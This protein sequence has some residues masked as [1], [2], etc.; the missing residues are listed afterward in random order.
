MLR[1]NTMTYDEVSAVVR[2]TIAEHFDLPIDVIRPETTAKDVEAWDSL[3]HAI[4]LIRLQ[5]ALGVEFPPRLSLSASTVKDF[6]G[7]LYAAHERNGNRL[8]EQ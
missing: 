8:A 1:D 3:Q 7:L 6:I 4:L 2:R 5:N